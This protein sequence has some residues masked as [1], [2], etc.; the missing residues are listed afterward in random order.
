MEHTSKPAHN[1]MKKN[2]M[3]IMGGLG[4][5]TARYDGPQDVARVALASGYGKEESRSPLGLKMLA[6]TPFDLTLFLTLFGFC[7]GRFV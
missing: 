3:E 6:K 7:S 2:I 1:Y 5:L 4:K